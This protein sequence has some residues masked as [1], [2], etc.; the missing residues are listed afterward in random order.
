MSAI[1]GF[2]SKTAQTYKSKWE[3][4]N[5]VLNNIEFYIVNFFWL[6]WCTRSELKFENLNWF[7]VTGVSLFLVP[8]FK[9]GNKSW[10]L[11]NI[12]VY[13]SSQL[14]IVVIFICYSSKIF[15]IHTTWATKIV[16]EYL[17]CFRGNGSSTYQN[18]ALW[19]N[20]KNKF[21]LFIHEL[22]VDVTKDL[23]LRSLGCASQVH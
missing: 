7:Q 12:E 14:I 23:I 20:R 17:H 13:S 21:S 9:K 10:S 5:F 4:Q 22:F 3:R 16:W 6:L 18:F 11:I 1:R 2:P 15:T 8:F 19:L